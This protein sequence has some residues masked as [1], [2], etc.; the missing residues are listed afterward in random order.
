MASPTVA[1]SATV[2]SNNFVNAQDLSLVAQ[3]N[4]RTDRPG[5]DVDKNGIVNA[6]DLGTVARV[7]FNSAA[8]PP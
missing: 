4:F 3:Q 7:F 1:K 5:E 6:A 2:N 8:C